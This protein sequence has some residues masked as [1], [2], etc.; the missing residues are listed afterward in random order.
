MSEELEQKASNRQQE[1][2]RDEISEGF[3]LLGLETEEKR[4]QFRI[5]AQVKGPEEECARIW[6]SGTT[7][8]DEAEG[9]DNA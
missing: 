5:M 2:S 1:L 9:G 4:Q 3:A 8:R 7:D 6:L